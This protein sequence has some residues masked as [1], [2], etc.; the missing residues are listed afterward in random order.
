MICPNCYSEVEYI[1]SSFEQ[2]DPSFYRC[3]GC[4]EEFTKEYARGMDR[5]K[6]KF[7]SKENFIRCTI[8]NIECVA[9]PIEVWDKLKELN[10]EIKRNI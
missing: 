8:G 7:I 3:T 9:V 10:N 1:E 5:I 2:Y 6:L 4:L